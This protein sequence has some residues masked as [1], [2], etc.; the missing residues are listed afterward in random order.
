MLRDSSQL[1]MTLMNNMLDSSKLAEGM[2]DIEHIRFDLTEVIQKTVHIIAIKAAEKGLNLFIHI[3]NSLPKAFI[4]DPLRISQ[5]LLNLLGNAIKFTNA[6]QIGLYVN[7]KKRPDGKYDVSIAVADS[8]IGIKEEVIGTIF[9]R[10]KQ[11]DA[12]ISRTF[13][14]TGLGL[15]ISQ[16]LAQLMHGY[17]TVKSRVGICPKSKLQ[18]R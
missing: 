6:G 11:A 18:A 3:N 5:I 4:G 13:G 16:D 15:S 9:D 1:L 17:I 14:G 8:G 7:A 12:S 2:M 10:Y